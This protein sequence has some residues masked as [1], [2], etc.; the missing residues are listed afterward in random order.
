[1]KDL[2]LPMLLRQSRTNLVLRL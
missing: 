1:M 2:R